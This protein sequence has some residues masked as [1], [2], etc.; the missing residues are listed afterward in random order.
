MREDILVTTNT[1]VEHSTTLISTA[2][3]DS[4]KEHLLPSTLV[5]GVVRDSL[6]LAIFCRQSLD[7]RALGS[8]GGG[9]GRGLGL[10]D[11][12]LRNYI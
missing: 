11:D 5:A 3:L 10:G 12:G 7:R 1:A 9:E 2:Q 6:G 8:Q 4:C